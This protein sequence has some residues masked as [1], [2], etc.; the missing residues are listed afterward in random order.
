[1][2]RLPWI[3]IGCHRSWT[4]FLLCVLG[5]HS[6]GFYLLHKAQSNSTRKK[7]AV[8]QSWTVTLWSTLRLSVIHLCTSYHEESA[9][10]VMLLIGFNGFN[11]ISPL[12]S[13]PVQRCH[14][15]HGS[16][17]LSPCPVTQSCV[18]PLFRFIIFPTPDFR[19][20]RVFR[21]SVGEIIEKLVRK[22]WSHF[23]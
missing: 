10:T 2:G 6:F 23:R 13:P 22:A 21:G 18:P 12:R 11:V 16:Y 1:M 7:Q 15:S 9:H 14:C 5:T 19:M 3:G 8:A 20:P 17:P 4:V